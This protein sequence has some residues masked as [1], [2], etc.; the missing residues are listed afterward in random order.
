MLYVTWLLLTF[1]GFSNTVA[2]L[3][4][5]ARAARASEATARAATA[6]E[7][8]SGDDVTTSPAMIA[9]GFK[10]RLLDARDASV[11]CRLFEVFSEGT[12]SLDEAELEAAAVWAPFKV[13]VDFDV[14]IPFLVAP[15]KLLMNDVVLVGFLK[16]WRVTLEAAM[17]LMVEANICEVVPTV[18]YFFSLT[19]SI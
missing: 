13:A 18:S 3:A 5:T 19:C 17:T 8:V 9:S 16:G 11:L 1:C 4:A 15:V 2:F 12:A 7:A 14:W 6:S 10:R